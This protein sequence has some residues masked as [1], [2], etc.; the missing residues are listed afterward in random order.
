MY[1]NKQV[2]QSIES[3]STKR[4]YWFTHELATYFLFGKWQI[5]WKN[6]YYHTT[7]VG[8]SNNFFSDLSVSYRTKEDEW[9]LEL[10]NMFG[11]S[12]Y[13]HHFI[14]NNYQLFSTIKLRQREVMVKYS[15]TF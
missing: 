4:E 13:S 14:S 6:E 3:V 1:S 15:W 12:T 8:A 5:K 2:N 11:N 9:A 7:M 10:N